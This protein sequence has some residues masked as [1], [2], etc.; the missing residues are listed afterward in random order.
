[1]YLMPQFRITRRTFITANG[2]IK[3]R[4]FR[5]AVEQ[6]NAYRV[7]IVNF[8]VY[9]ERNGIMAINPDKRT[10]Y[11]VFGD[12]IEDAYAFLESTDRDAMALIV[13]REDL[14]YFHPDVYAH[15]LEFFNPDDYHSWWIATRR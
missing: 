15:H 10:V 9:T 6:Y 12:G 4:S 11:F 14:K 1:M 13:F 3:A 8:N 7:A 5:I 2:L